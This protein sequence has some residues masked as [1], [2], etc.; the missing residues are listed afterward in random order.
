MERPYPRL[1]ITEKAE[2]L[3]RQGHA[4]VYADEIT[5]VEGAYEN[6]DIVDV[7][8]K[9]GRWLGAGFV[10]DHSKIRVRVI[11]QNT[12][13]RFDEAF[14]ARRFSALQATPG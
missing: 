14:F 12:N 8:S 6:G 9:K 13:D 4:W 2:K 5:A 10:N 7:V 1:Q 3:L 11:S